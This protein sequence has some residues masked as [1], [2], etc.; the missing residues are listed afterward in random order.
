MVKR[1][2]LYNLCQINGPNGAFAL[3][4]F[5]NRLCEDAKRPHSFFLMHTDIYM[6]TNIRTHTR[7][8]TVNDDGSDFI[9][10]RETNKRYPF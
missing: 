1:V 2:D 4:R 3:F 6:N 7:V 9:V 5:E 10:V 8:I